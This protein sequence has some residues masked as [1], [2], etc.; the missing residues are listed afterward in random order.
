MKYYSIRLCYLGLCASWSV[1]IFVLTALWV[2]SAK[3][4]VTYSAALLRGIV[5]DSTGAA[6]P[7]ATVTIT[8]DATKVS[9]KKTTDEMGRYIFNDLRPASYTVKVE[10]QGFKTVERSKVVLRVG[11]QTDLDFVLEVGAVSTTVE[12][13]GTTPML[14][15]VS[16]ALG[17]EVDNRY[18]TEMPLFNREI[19]RLAFLAPG[20][21][22]VQGGL[23]GYGEVVG[24]I[25]GFSGSGIN[26]TSGGQGNSTAEV[27]LDG[28]VT[29]V[30]EGGGGWN[31]VVNYNPSPEFLQEFKIQTNSFSA[32]YGQ[33]GGTVINMVTKSGTNSF[34]GSG[35]WFGRRPELNANNFFS[36]RAGEKKSPF[37]RD[38]Y[39]GSIGGPII[40]Q[41][42]FFF[43]DY[44]RIRFNAPSTLTT[45]VPTALQKQGDFSKTFNPDGSL[46]QIFNP[47]AALTPV[48]DANGNI[49]DYDRQ[50]LPGNVI[51]ND[52]L[53]PLALKLMSFYPD[54]T[55]PGDSVT[56]FNNFTKSAI[57]ATPVYKYDGKID[58][59]FSERSRLSGRYSRT[60][61]RTISPKYFNN[62][63]DASGNAKVSG[64]NA[65]LEH[66]WTLNPT[67]LWTNRISLD[68]SRIDQ[69][70][71]SIDLT[72]LGF[73]GIL[74]D[75]NGKGRFPWIL[76]GSYASLGP[77]GWTDIITG[78]TL[79]VLASSL[80]KV[81]GPHSLKFGGEERLWF[82]N[83]WQPGCIVGCFPFSSLPTTQQVFN[84]QPTQGNALAALLLD[85]GDPGDWGGLSIQ[86][87]TSTFS[88][89]N[90][91]F[92]QDDWRATQRLT[93]NLG[94]RYE[95]TTPFTERR[96]I[97]QVSGWNDDTGVDVP[98]LGRLRGVN[99][100]LGANH[101]HVDADMNN[102][103]PRVGLAYRLSPKTV[104]RGGAGVYYLIALTHNNWLPGPAYRHFSVWRPSLDGGLTPFATLENPFPSGVG[105]PQGMKYGKLNMWGFD[106]QN[107]WSMS[108]DHLVN[109]ELYQWNFGLE[110]Q[111]TNNL[112]LE[113]TYVGSRSTHYA[114]FGTENRNFVGRA[115]REKYGSAGL[116][117][118]VPNPFQPLFN[119]ANAI[120]DEPDSIYN[121]DTLP[122]VYLLRPYPQFNNFSGNSRLA[123][124]SIYHA[125]ELRV[126][127]RYSNGLNFIGHY[128]WSR[129]IDTNSV[130][131]A[132]W[133][134]HAVGPQDPTN[135]NSEKSTGMNETPHRF[136]FAW[137]YELPVGHGR[138][139]GGT[140]NS[141]VDAVLGGW[142]FN[143]LLSFQSGH[144]IYVGMYIPRLADGSQLPNVTGNP[145]SSSSIKGVVDGKG[146][147]DTCANF[148]NVSAFS[149][150]GDQIP[151]NSPRYNSR[152][153]INGI[154]NF[155]FSIFKKFRFRESKEIQ[156]RAEF[157]NFTNTPR[158][159][160]PDSSFG[161]PTFGIISSQI[162]SAR[163]A[164][165]GVRFVF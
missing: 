1:T 75:V 164:Q 134:G 111:L 42:T 2:P 102:F 12:V 71:D 121:Y 6:V 138:R 123:A 150:P 133:L 122:R 126:E 83:Y 65:V 160:P 132:S 58:H 117:E 163:Q 165:M 86:P 137:G 78:T 114:F 8:N 66:T 92:V 35:Y 128:T 33:N 28:G 152:L 118:L 81:V 73:S 158:F 124:S 101:R 115:D 53:S 41:K 46:M 149:D 139:F 55:G 25:S 31:N 37:A 60:L 130:S 9:E 97:V 157:F 11:Q 57:S 56:G 61:S 44:D 99:R 87:G 110:H 94:L 43:F 21:S 105:Y 17:Q 32:E 10:A 15:T 144:P 30:P 106:A 84:P 39:G 22:E 68:R 103:A 29:S 4:Q 145:R 89:D 63:A 109:P 82:S 49:A 146:C 19:I 27:R 129:W 127:K 38:Q 113:L 162:N 88:R 90:A 40:R 100:F 54:P 52:M 96:N 108:S 34:H 120:F 156:L 147:P 141:G 36:N 148:F 23:F 3:G 69:A 140:W 18:V 95:W 59:M 16:A 119:G 131:G 116:Q 151:G 45:T 13:K 62:A 135:L 107:Y 143:G 47:F 85:F 125:L 153:R 26:F 112:V 136:V 80:S 98:G 104:L 48:T 14:N 5:Q 50:P 142:Q 155:D 51:P 20:V 154:N 67:T 93:V 72:T 64:H 7:G 74:Q 70:P 79:S 161:S 91:L 77:P 24:S 159:G 76:P